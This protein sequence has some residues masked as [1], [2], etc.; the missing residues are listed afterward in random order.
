M[1][2]VNILLIVLFLLTNSC[3][4]SKENKIDNVWQQKRFE[5]YYL[6]IPPGYKLYF[7]TKDSINGV[8]SNGEI[9]NGEI[10]NGVVSNGDMHI[11]IIGGYGGVANYNYDAKILKSKVIGSNK[12]KMLTYP[13]GIRKGW[14]VICVWDTLKS[15]LY[16]GNGIYSHTV[17][18]VKNVNPRQK[19]MISK[20][21]ESITPIAYTVHK[22][23]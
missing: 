11:G 1:K 3:N 14:V 9:I 23:K 10:I 18:T 16:K 15:F 22:E 21:F 7:F 5:N 12:G 20:I 17:L 19:D 13:S 4:K 6:K 2:K 8:I